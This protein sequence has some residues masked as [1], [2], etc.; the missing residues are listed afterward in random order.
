[1][2]SGGRMGVGERR[3]GRER[4]QKEREKGEHTL[5]TSIFVDLPENFKQVKHINNM[6][7]SHQ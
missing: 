3:R 4:M 1:M 6:A 2:V 5:E 7:I